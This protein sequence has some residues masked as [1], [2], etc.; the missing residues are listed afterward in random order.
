[1]NQLGLDELR[2]RLRASVDNKA[3]KTRKPYKKRAKVRPTGAEKAEMMKALSDAAEFVKLA[4]AERD[5]L[6]MFYYRKGMTDADLSKALGV[7]EGTVASRLDRIKTKINNTP[8][9]A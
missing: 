4:L 9:T 2:E 3:T 8:T 7:A 5:A 6:T 1:M